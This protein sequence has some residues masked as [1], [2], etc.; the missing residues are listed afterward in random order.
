M[1]L[2]KPSSIHY[3]FVALKINESI[4]GFMYACLCIVDGNME[5]YNTRVQ[6]QSPGVLEYKKSINVQG[7][8]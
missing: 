6:K 7:I 4:S 3:I 5:L 2:I 1:N 8:F